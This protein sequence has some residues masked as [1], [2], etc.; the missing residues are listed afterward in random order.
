MQ[1]FG[2]S[3]DD[4]CAP[5]PAR[6]CAYLLLSGSMTYFQDKL[7][8]EASDVAQTR[9]RLE[10]GVQAQLFEAR[11]GSLRLVTCIIDHIL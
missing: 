7:R 10:A 5:G 6:P 1:L 9:K 8:L 3:G 11:H 2:R 4:L